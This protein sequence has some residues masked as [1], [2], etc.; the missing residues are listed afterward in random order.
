MSQ[1][2]LECGI[3]QIIS[4]QLLH[5]CIYCFRFSFLLDPVEM[6]KRLEDMMDVAKV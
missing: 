1:Y 6:E 4:G 5:L 2:N 3:D